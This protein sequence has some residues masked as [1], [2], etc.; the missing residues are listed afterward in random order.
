MVFPPRSARVL[1]AL[2]VVT[3]LVPLMQACGGRS[4]TEDYLYGS[5]GTITT[6]ARTGTAGRASTGGTR[7]ANGGASSTA[8]RN[9][10]AGTSAT[11][12]GGTVT[13]GGGGPIQ[14]GEPATGGTGATA[15]VGGTGTAGTGIAGAG[16]AVMVTPVVCG[17]QVCDA[18]TQSC[19]AGLSGLSCIRKNQ[20]CDGAVLGCTVN[21]DCAGNGVC[22]ISITGDVAEASSCKAS[23]DFMGGG[24]DR[25]LCQ[26]DDECAPPFHY[27]TATIFGVNIC[28]R[29]P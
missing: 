17:T 27:C 5:D 22:C 19:C 24:R 26:T 21:A 6:G 7:G 28:T 16:G 20:A 15:P 12:F 9:G 29:R 13:V 18:A 10:T 1:R 25:Q 3:C 11:S 14:A 23:C 8:G 2:V 4:D